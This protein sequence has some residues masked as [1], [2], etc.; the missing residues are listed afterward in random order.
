MKTVA[1]ITPY[2]AIKNVP[3]VGLDFQ[4]RMSNRTA[5]SDNDPIKKRKINHFPFNAT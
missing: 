4:N 1:L 2:A 3:F 5:L